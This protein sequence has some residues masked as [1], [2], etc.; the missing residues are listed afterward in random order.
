MIGNLNSN[1]IEE[2][3]K[4]QLVGRLGC[5]ADNLTYVVPVSYAYDGVYVY[6]HTYEG[7]KMDL[8]RKN[9]QVCFQVDDM[10][11]MANWK[12]VIAWG[13]VEE[14]TD[15]DDRNEAFKKLSARVL[16][17]MSSETTHLSPIWPFSSDVQSV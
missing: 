2:L 5:H 14:L 3:L 1:E 10:N 16:P 11:N 15:A 13:T 6:S 4:V 7:L 17:F 9:P 8:I 12:S